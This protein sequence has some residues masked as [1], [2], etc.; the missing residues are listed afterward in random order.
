MRSLVVV[1]ACD[2][3]IELGID[4]LFDE[5]RFQGDSARDHRRQSQRVLLPPPVPARFMATLAAPPGFSS[6]VALERP[7]P[8]P[9]E[10]YAPPRPKRID[11]AS[12]RQPRVRER[13]AIP[14]PTAVRH[15]ANSASYGARDIVTAWLMQLASSTHWHRM[16]PKGCGPPECEPYS[17]DG[18]R[19][20]TSANAAMCTTVFPV[21]LRSWLAAAGLSPAQRKRCGCFPTSRCRRQH[22][23]AGTTPPPGA[24]KL[25]RS[26]SR[27]RSQ[28]ERKYLWL[29]LWKPG[30]SADDEIARPIPRPN[31]ERLRHC[32]RFRTIELYAHVNRESVIRMA[33]RSKDPA[34]FQADG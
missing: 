10:R 4:A 6:R 24:R 33:A 7:A 15:S 34:G 8:E 14:R 1:G 27:W 11:P 17:S 5:Q 13:A 19:M 22:P 12:S 3:D 31:V 23:R 25:R 26:R 29:G 30:Q 21:I 18:T 2:S 20:Q 28:S 32:R 16:C 9:R